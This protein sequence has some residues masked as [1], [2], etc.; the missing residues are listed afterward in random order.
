MT[1]T[2]ALVLFSMIWFLTFYIVLQVRTRT[3]ADVGGEVVPGTPR[4][5]AAVEDVGKSAKIATLYALAIWAV[6]AGIIISGWISI[7]DIDI[8]NRLEFHNLG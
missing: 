2:A 6:I 5:A 8:F 4:S 3:Q 1:I 7:E